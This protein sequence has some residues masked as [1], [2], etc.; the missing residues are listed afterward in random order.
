MKYGNYLPLFEEKQSG[1]TLIE[2]VVTVA[3]SGILLA[4]IS[5]L[6]ISSNKMH[7][8][9]EQVL[10]IQQEVR[11]G[12]DMIARDVRMAGYNPTDNANDAGFTVANST[13]L[14]IEYD[15]DEDGVCNKD[16][17]YKYNSG[18]ENL[19]V[20]RDGSGGFQTFINDVNSMNFQYTLA[21]G[22]TT[23]NPSDTE[24][25][26]RVTINICGQISG[27]YS[28]SYDNSYCFNNVITCRN[29]GM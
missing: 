29:M 15:F 2:L 6:F 24:E 23:N 28:D 27:G 21:D 7:T 16:R 26:R 8:V 9:Q 11:Y 13:N 19:E 3:V 20:Q 4:A 17:E 25:I 10:R 5:Q 1:F 22:T 12:L 14:R 18:E